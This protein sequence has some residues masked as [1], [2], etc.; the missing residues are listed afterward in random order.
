MNQSNVHLNFAKLPQEEQLSNYAPKLSDLP[1]P[2]I[3]EQL[4]LSGESHNNSTIIKKSAE[5]I[6]ATDVRKTIICSNCNYKGEASSYYANGRAVVASS[7]V[8]MFACCPLIWLPWVLK[9]FKDI[10]F[11]CPECGRQHSR[12]RVI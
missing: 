2:D 5:P 12:R 11:E 1:N 3:Q 10:V 9:G 4:Q 8:L 6:R 7:L